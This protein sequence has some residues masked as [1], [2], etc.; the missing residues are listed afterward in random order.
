MNVSVV[1]R[2]GFLKYFLEFLL[3]PLNFFQECFYHIRSKSLFANAIQPPA[4][5]DLSTAAGI[6]FIISLILYAAIGDS[7]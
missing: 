2:E 1:E 7:W 4:A 6:F 3:K 5:G